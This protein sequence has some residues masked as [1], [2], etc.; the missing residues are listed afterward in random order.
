MAGWIS[1]GAAVGILLVILWYLRVVGH[2]FERLEALHVEE[3]EALGRPKLGFQFGDPRYRNAMRYIRSR[4]FASLNDTVLGAH[5]RL[6]KRLE[7]TALL[8]SAV[9]LIAAAMG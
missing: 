5:Y 3:F 2:F 6:L 9:L 1:L 8:A 4:A 7:A